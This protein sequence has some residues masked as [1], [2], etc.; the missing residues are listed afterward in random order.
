MKS[1]VSIAC[2]NIIF[3]FYFNY[4]YCYSLRSVTLQMISGLL[5]IGIKYGFILS[6]KT[7][8]E[9]NLKAFIHA[10]SHIIR[11]QVS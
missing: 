1:C 9:P 4:Y 11:T 3:L 8:K 5:D 6:L 7:V 10:I 2:E